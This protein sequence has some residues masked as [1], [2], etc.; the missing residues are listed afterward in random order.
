MSADVA[1]IIVNYRTPALT[2][3]AATSLLAAGV[4]EV[5]VV[6][7]DSRDGSAEAVDDA[8]GSKVKLLRNDRNAGFGTAANRGAA[9]A[10][11]EHLFFLNSDAVVEADTVPVLVGRLAEA[12]D[13]GL[14]AP[15][16][17]LPDGREQPD[18]YGTFP[19]LSTMVRRVN[20]N[21][22]QTTEP[23]W[24]SGLAFAARRAEFLALGGFD[25]RIHMYFEDV[26][27]CRTY[28]RAGLRVERVLAATVVHHRGG[29]WEQDAERRR[30]YDEAQLHYFRVIGTPAPAVA[31]LRGMLWLGC[32]LGLRATAPS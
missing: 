13:V 2:V 29:S 1:G 25:E 9:T 3:A 12:A 14:V 22:T 23:D 28:R 31:A 20:R 30:A 11:A 21:P 7:N 6:D 16:V 10:D 24:V 5:V 8:L 4:A 32:R 26:L 19:S 27:L 17:V 15:R 18:A